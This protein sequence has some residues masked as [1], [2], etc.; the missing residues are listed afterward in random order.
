[1]TVAHILHFEMMGFLWALAATVFIQILTRR[2][3]LN[4]ILSEDNVPG[5][6][7]P[8]RVQLM[9]ATFAASITYLSQVANSSNGTMPDIDPNWLYLFG[10]SGSIYALEQGWAAW[11]RRKKV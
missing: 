3:K 8:G 7:S 1:M 10:G 2:I 11:K 6:V 5:K 4:G 9:L